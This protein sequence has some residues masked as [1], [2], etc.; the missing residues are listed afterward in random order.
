MLKSIMIEKASTEAHSGLFK[1]SR[2]EKECEMM[3][4][5]HL[6]KNLTQVK[7]LLINQK[8]GKGKGKVEIV[9]Q[10][11]LNKIAMLVVQ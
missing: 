7:I 10:L 3:E 11:K 5:E 2:E 4:K 8:K 9:K 1:P 6:K